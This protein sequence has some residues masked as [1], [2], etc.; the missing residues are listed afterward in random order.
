VRIHYREA[1]AGKTVVFLHGGWGYGYY[2]IDAQIAAF[3]GQRRFVIPDRTG[4]GDSSQVNGAMGMDFHRRAAE[5]MRA[6]LEAAGIAKCELWGHSDGAVIAAMMG[7]AEPERYERIV[8]EAFHFYKSKPGSGEFFER[9]AVNPQE[10]LGERSRRKLAADHGEGR[11]E[12]VVRRNSDVWVRIA[13]SKRTP[14]EDLFG[15]GLGM[16]AVPTL[17]IHGRQDPRTEPGEVERA[18]RSVRGSVLRFIEN[19]R[20]CPHYESAVA[21]EF[22]RVLGDFL[23]VKS[24]SGSR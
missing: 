10:V 14:D 3:G 21:E 2:P 19:G 9:L 18:A 24:R 6:F 8:L 1:G 12:E 4:Y 15:G 23:E 7:L 11:W 17:F 16:L 5:E 22:N 20:H 13:E